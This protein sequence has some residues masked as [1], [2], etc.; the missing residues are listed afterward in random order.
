MTKNETKTRNAIKW[1]MDGGPLGSR[2][3]GTFA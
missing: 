2:R 1:Q 3:Q